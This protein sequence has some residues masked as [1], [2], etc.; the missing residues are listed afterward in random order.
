MRIITLRDETRKEK[1]LNRLAAILCL[2]VWTYLCLHVGAHIERQGAAEQE[3]LFLRHYAQKMEEIKKKEEALIYAVRE[4]RKAA[5]RRMWYGQE[6]RT[7]KDIE[8]QKRGSAE[9]RK[10]RP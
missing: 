6:T 3:D 7:E 8:G 4:L 2:I 9:G 10:Q 1:W 5:K